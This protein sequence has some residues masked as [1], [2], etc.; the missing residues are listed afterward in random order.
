[1]SRSVGAAGVGNAML[2]P[3]GV[4]WGSPAR[5][6]DAADSLRADALSRAEILPTGLLNENPRAAGFADSLRNVKRAVAFGTNLDHPHQFDVA[7]VRS[8]L[9]EQ[10]LSSAYPEARTFL[11]YHDL[12]RD[13]PQSYFSKEKPVS[14]ELIEKYKALQNGEAAVQYYGVKFSGP[15][16]SQLLKAAHPELAAH[17]WKPAVEASRLEFLKHPAVYVPIGVGA[18]VLLGLVVHTRNPAMIQTTMKWAE[19]QLSRIHLPAMPWSGASAISE[20]VTSRVSQAANIDVPLK[21]AAVQFGGT[22]PANMSAKPDVLSQLLGSNSPKSSIASKVLGHVSD[23]LPA[24][25]ERQTTKPGIVQYRNRPMR[26][27]LWPASKPE[28]TPPATVKWPSPQAEKVT[29]RVSQAASIDV[30]LKKAAV[31]FGGTLPANMSAKPDVLSQ[32]LGSNS[33][34]SSIASKVLGHV[35]DGLPAAVERQPPQLESFQYRN[36]PTRLTERHAPQSESN[37][38]HVSVSFR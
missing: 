23:G 6:N 20:K 38:G 1:M 2:Q 25:V 29:S 3:L 14:K 37:T 8:Y 30:P 5:R 27:A 21:K 22:L 24:A 12:V 31:Q 16:Y 35:S 19:S 32:L 18:L 17:D 33:P 15:R 34:K 26:L 7:T 13:V 10:K 11:A 28:P 9:A 36:H 4:A